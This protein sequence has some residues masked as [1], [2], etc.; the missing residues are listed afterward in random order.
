MKHM[1][2]TGPTH[3][4]R[5]AS[6]TLVLCA[7][8]A[9]AQANPD[10]RPVA[11][12]SKSGQAHQEG[13]QARYWTG[14]NGNWENATHWSLHPGGIGGAGAPGANDDAVIDP[15]GAATIT[16]ARDAHCGSLRVVGD[17]GTVIIA[18]IPRST[19][20]IGGNWWLEG[21]VQWQHAGSV[22]LDA[23]EGVQV[24]ATGP[25]MIH[26]DVI[27]DATATWDLT[28]ALL[29]ADDRSLIL[30]KGTLRSNGRA[31]SRTMSSTIFRT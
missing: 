15:I 18:G 14:G 8:M 4:L 21:D 11:A 23:R 31:R 29:I 13:G 27:V 17:E 16:I 12:Q 3:F 22:V 20:S 30:R 24:I 25:V 26:A 9:H 19:L 1:K 28:G 6:G 2:R 10:Q 7:T 5:I